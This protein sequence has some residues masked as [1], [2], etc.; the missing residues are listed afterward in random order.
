MPGVDDQDL[1]QCV[2]PANKVMGKL[3]PGK[4]VPGGAELGARSI[5]NGDDTNWNQIGSELMDIIMEVCDSVEGVLLSVCR[6]LRMDEKLWA[7]WG[8]NWANLEK[9]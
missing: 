8:R 7:A 9:G 6:W 2:D 5:D 3:M 1:D 4:S